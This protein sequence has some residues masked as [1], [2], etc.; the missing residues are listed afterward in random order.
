MSWQAAAG[1]GLGAWKAYEAYKF[2]KDPFKYAQSWGF[3]GDPPITFG[4]RKRQR[5]KSFPAN[6]SKA[7]KLYNEDNEQMPYGRKSRRKPG[8]KGVYQGKR[9]P[10]R[11]GYT[12]RGSA[13]GIKTF[14]KKVK[15]KS[16][17]G[18]GA[19]KLFD[20]VAPPLTIYNREFI[21]RQLTIDG[22]A[23]VSKNENFDY[24]ADPDADPPVA[25]RTVT[26]M[27]DEIGSSDYYPH[28]AQF[29]ILTTRE[30]L[31]YILKSINTPHSIAWNYHHHGVISNAA[32]GSHGSTGHAHTTLADIPRET[33]D[34]LE[35]AGNDTDILIPAAMSLTNVYGTME[36]FKMSYTFANMNEC[37]VWVDVYE[38]RPRDPIEGVTVPLN[39]LSQTASATDQNSHILN[40]NVNPLALIKYDCQKKQAK[41]QTRMN[42][43]VDSDEKFPKALDL[44]TIEDDWKF[45][46]DISACKEFNKH[47]VCLQKKTVCLKPGERYQYDVVIPGFGMRFDKYIKTANVSHSL[48]ATDKRVTLAELQ[49]T[50]T[51]FMLVKHRSVRM[52]KLMQQRMTN[53]LTP[54]VVANPN[55]NPPVLAQDEF[56]T[57]EI[58]PSWPIDGKQAYLKD[59]KITVRASKYVRTRLMPRTERNISLRTGGER[60]IDFN[61]VMPDYQKET[62]MSSRNIGSWNGRNLYQVN[63]Y[64]NAQMIIGGNTS[65][66]I[67]SGMDLT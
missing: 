56:E 32:A 65:T 4:S 35:F 1:I 37:S 30:A 59:C 38:C 50:F 16:A 5:V 41:R 45:T 20:M 51:R 8:G 49:S 66:V 52:F 58:T 62:E 29:P 28:W 34:Q 23:D 15:G 14:K 2:A 47:Y 17:K 64:P 54:A 11:N 22:K 67:N 44:E 42:N 6:N 46:K 60:D 31:T 12:K 40:L 55:A 10:G 57:Q 36:G 18:G 9:V 19:S 7:K 63:R 53:V 48:T 24:P 61:G 21:P 25:A 33:G 3:G 13:P 26:R 27:K 39:G 43:G